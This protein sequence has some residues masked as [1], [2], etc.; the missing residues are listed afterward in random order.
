M[1]RLG[2]VRACERE[3]RRGEESH[4]GEQKRILW[5]VEERGSVAD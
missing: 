3:P 1:P 4:E 5:H 2:C